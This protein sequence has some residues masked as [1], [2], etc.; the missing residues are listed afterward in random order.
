M[1]N[2][3]SLTIENTSVKYQLVWHGMLLFLISLDDYD[4]QYSNC[5]EDFQM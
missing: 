1:K 2:N 3:Q 5:K 4:R